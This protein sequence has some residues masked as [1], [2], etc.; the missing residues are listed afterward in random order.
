MRKPGK[1]KPAACHTSVWPGK[2]V[3]V[4]LRDGGYFVDVF[5]R[6]GRAHIEFKSCGR[7]P[8]VKIANMGI[9]KG[10]QQA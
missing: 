5:V 4:K 9:Y 2:R 8:I 6:R 7:V 3:L 1:R 10:E